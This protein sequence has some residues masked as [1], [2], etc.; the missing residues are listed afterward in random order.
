MGGGAR[1]CARAVGL[2]G[3]RRERCLYVRGE[4][5]KMCISNVRHLKK[6]G[7]DGGSHME[8]KIEEVGERHKQDE[9]ERKKEGNKP[10]I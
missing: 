2:V 6:D 3:K 4:L 5:L 8:R 9:K 7:S 10:Q 1:P